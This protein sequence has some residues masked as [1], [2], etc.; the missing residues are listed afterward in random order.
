MS[1]TASIIEHM[2]KIRKASSF[3]ATRDFNALNNNTIALMV[4]VSTILELENFDED[5]FEEITGIKI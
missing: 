3:C 1:K 5:I 2:E 4:S